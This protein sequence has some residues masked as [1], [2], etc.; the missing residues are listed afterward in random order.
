MT[1][2]PKA[3]SAVERSMPSARMSSH[4]FSKWAKSL[5]PSPGG[6]ITISDAI[7]ALANP[8]ASV[9][10]CSVATFASVTT[11]TRFWRSTLCMRSPASASNP[12]PATMS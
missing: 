3:T 1:P 12:D 7:S 8:A 6:R 5:V 9:F 4:S 11:T 2:P 10:K